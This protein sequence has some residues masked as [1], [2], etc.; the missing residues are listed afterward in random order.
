MYCNYHFFKLL[1]NPLRNKL[2]GKQLLTCFSQEKDELIL[3]FGD[4]DGDF[5]IKCSVKSTFGGLYF[6]ETFHR[7]RQNSVDLFEEVIGRKVTKVFVFEN[8]RAF[9]IELEGNLAIVLKMYGNRSNVILYE[10]DSARHIFNNKLKDDLNLNYSAFAKTINQSFSA[11][12]AAEGK[13]ATLFPTWGKIPKLYFEANKTGKTEADWQLVQSIGSLIKRGKFYL[14]R[15]QNEL[16][17]SLLRFG[18]IIQQF[19]DPFT[20]ANTFYVEKQKTTQFESEQRAALKKLQKELKNAENYL[21]KTTQRLDTLL[22]GPGNQA[23]GHLIMAHLYEVPKE[24]TSVTLSDFQT[25]KPVKI[26]LKKDLS[27]QKNAELYY[28]KAKKEKIELEILEKNLLAKELEIEKLNSQIEIIE[29]A[30]SLKTLRGLVKKEEITTKKSKTPKAEDLF[31]VFEIDGYKIW[32]GKNAK[33]NDLLTLKYSHK[34]DTWLHAKD[35]SGS[36]VVIKE[37]AGQKTPKTVLEAAAGL[38]AW[39]SKKRNDTMVPVAYTPKKF[40]RKIKGT[41]DGAVMV[42]KED[43]LLTEP[44]DPAKLV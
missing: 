21:A 34:N 28:R 37:I 35:V 11:F 26:R 36:H 17:L 43:V 23:I 39:F 42:E 19:D 27:A 8:E 12:E 40:V 15:F 5:Y 9:S 44:L 14:I 32:I 13:P 3:G 24:S 41:P 22:M 33:N 20:A 29:N 16:H 25:G 6:S 31:K 7:A 1:E 2:E 18:E 10:G 4:Q 38:A 30:D